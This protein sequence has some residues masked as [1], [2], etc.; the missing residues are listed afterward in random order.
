[1][2]KN[3]LNIK[4]LFSATLGVVLSFVIVFNLFTYS[5]HEIKEHAIHSETLCNEEI[6]K[7]ACHRFLVHHEESTSCDK[8]HRHIEEKEDVCFVCKYFKERKLDVTIESTS[9]TWLFFTECSYTKNSIV[10]IEKSLPSFAY[11]RGPPVFNS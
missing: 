5:I 10:Q 6:E 4:S 9:F 11:L 8:T 3:S 2:K 7:D 1:M